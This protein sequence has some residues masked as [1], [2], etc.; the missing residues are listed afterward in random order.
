MVLLQIGSLEYRTFIAKLRKESTKGRKAPRVKFYI[1]RTATHIKLELKLNDPENGI[2]GYKEL[3]EW[4]LKEF[5][6]EIYLFL[7]VLNKKSSN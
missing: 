7:S 3:Q 1:Y 6:N 4:V 2:R 5:K